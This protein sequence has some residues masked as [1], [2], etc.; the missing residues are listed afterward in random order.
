MQMEVNFLKDWSEDS[1]NDPES[2]GVTELT[3][4]ISVPGSD[5][6]I[7]RARP[8]I[9]YVSWPTRLNPQELGVD[10]FLKN[11]PLG[12]WTA[13]R[14]D[15]QLDV[16]SLR[17]EAQMAP[18]LRE[19]AKVAD[20]LDPIKKTSYRLSAE[21][22]REAARQ[23]WDKPEDIQSVAYRIDGH[24]LWL[25]VPILS[26]QGRQIDNASI[27]LPRQIPFHRYLAEWI[28]DNH[29]DDQFKSHSRML[30][31]RIGYAHNRANIYLKNKE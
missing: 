2:T 26:D 22:E 1:S 23:M 18:Y 14:R 6:V 11:N 16:Y 24:K 15:A 9:H 12:D 21:A 31:T 27:E 17:E 4:R 10:F 28:V 20:L 5:V 13:E 8:D 29:V 7:Y 25:M 19:G 30:G 3:Y